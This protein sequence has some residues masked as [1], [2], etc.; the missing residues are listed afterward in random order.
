MSFTQNKLPPHIFKRYG[1]TRRF[2]EAKRAEFKEIEKTIGSFR[3]CCWYVPGYEAFS[4][5]QKSLN[6]I[7]EEMSIKKWGR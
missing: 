3:L 1:T 7:K 4:S 5:V 2:K 6:D